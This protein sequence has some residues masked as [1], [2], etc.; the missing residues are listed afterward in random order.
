MNEIV[1]RE[2]SKTHSVGISPDL[3]DGAKTPLLVHL[4]AFLA[5]R[6]AHVSPAT[7]THYRKLLEKLWRR[8][9]WVR[10]VDVTSASFLRWQNNSNLSPKYVNDQLGAMRTFWGW[11]E[12][13][14]L[15]VHDPLKH[16][17]KLPNHSVGA[18]R[19]ALSSDEISRL[20]KA[21][22]RNRASLYLIAIYTGLRRK[23]MEA[24]KWGDFDLD[25]DKPCIRLPATITKN[26]RPALVA[27]HPEAVSAIRAFRADI[28]AAYEW[29][30]RG[31]TRVPA[32]CDLKKDLEK[33][34]I[35]FQDERGRRVDIHAMRHTLGTLLHLADVPIREAQ[36]L[37][38]HSDVRL[39]MKIYTDASQLRI[40]EAVA[41]LPSFA[42]R[43]DD[44]QIHSQAVVSDGLGETQAGTI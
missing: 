7:L 37:M 12:R 19:R 13:E 40:R 39:T 21:A 4:A 34:G 36:E 41:R 33:A 27:L 31:E 15:V 32:V 8:L 28:A 29:A 6:K 43:S 11:M 14:G 35:P 22:P 30:F 26:R 10:L 44:S 5:T 1:K 9:G 3:I 25:S 17:E 42:L 24:L 23:E 20:I 16:V 2:E 38:R 18:Y